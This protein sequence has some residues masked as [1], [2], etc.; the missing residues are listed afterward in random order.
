MNDVKS[1]LLG[2]KNNFKFYVGCADETNGESINISL[3]LK[4]S[5]TTLE[6]KVELNGS[7]PVLYIYTSG[8]TGL[9]KAV[10]FKNTRV[11]YT[12][13]GIFYGTWPNADDVM[14][15]YLPMYHASG[16]INLFFIFDIFTNSHIYI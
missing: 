3:E 12:N 16:G 1:K 4:K 11:I 15:S 14:Y 6:N 9:P 13:C 5:S 2:Y 7:D 10:T 8:T